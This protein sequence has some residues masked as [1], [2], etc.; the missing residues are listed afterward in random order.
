MIAEDGQ[1]RF[2]VDSHASQ[3]RMRW[4]LR[5]EAT[6]V[7]DPFDLARGMPCRCQAARGVSIGGPSDPT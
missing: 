3:D 7:T 1:I 2:S 4:L 6:V 5:M